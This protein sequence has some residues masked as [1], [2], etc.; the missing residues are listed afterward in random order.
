MLV[1]IDKKGIYTHRNLLA[2][3]SEITSVIKTE[4]RLMK[5]LLKLAIARQALGLGLSF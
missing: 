1:R 2:D 4:A 5:A 3:L